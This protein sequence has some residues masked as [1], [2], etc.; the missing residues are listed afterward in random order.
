[1]GAVETVGGSGP[2]VEATKGE[3][4][5]CGGLVCGGSSDGG[6]KGPDAR[7]VLEEVALTGTVEASGVEGECTGDQ[8]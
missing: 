2:K 8:G 7:A 1:M 3:G 4:E 6:E 5:R